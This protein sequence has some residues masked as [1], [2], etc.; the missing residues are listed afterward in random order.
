[1]GERPERAMETMKTGLACMMMTIMIGMTS[2]CASL[3]PKGP[4]QPE[5][6]VPKG[7]KSLTGSSVEA[8]DRS[9]QPNSEHPLEEVSELAPELMLEEVPEGETDS[10]GALEA[11]IDRWDYLRANPLN[12]NK[13]SR[14]QL[15]ML[16]GI[17][18]FWVDDLLR[19]RKQKGAFFSPKEA[20]EATII[21]EF[22]WRRWSTYVTVGPLP[23]RI[24]ARLR[25]PSAWWSEADWSL[26]TT[27]RSA[28][29][30]LNA[31]DRPPA[32]FWEP[33]GLRYRLRWTSP[34]F[35]L[36]MHLSPEYGSGLLQKPISAA[37][38][39]LASLPFRGELILGTYLLGYGLGLSMGDARVM[40]TGDQ[41]LET[42]PTGFKHRSYIGTSYSLPHRG[43]S[44]SIGDSLRW[45][46]WFSYRPYLDSAQDIEDTF[47]QPSAIRNR[48]GWAAYEPSPSSDAGGRIPITLQML[49][50]RLEY[51][52]RRGQVALSWWSAQLIVPAASTLNSVALEGEMSPR[53][54]PL[55]LLSLD[56]DWVLPFGHFQ[57]EVALDRRGNPAGILHLE[58]EAQGGFRWLAHYRHLRPGYESPFGKTYTRWGTIPGNE[59]GLYLGW[60]Y[61]PHRQ[62]R[63][64]SFGDLYQSIEPRTNQL[65]PHQGVLYGVALEWSP[66]HARLLLKARQRRESSEEPL[67]DLYGRSY[68]GLTEFLQ[69]TLEARIEGRITASLQGIQRLML[70]HTPDQHGML[71]AQELRWQPHKSL[72]VHGRVATYHTDSDGPP[73]YVY[74]PDPVTMGR[75]IRLSGLGIRTYLLLHFQPKDW[76]KLQF[77][78]MDQELPLDYFLPEKGHLQQW[79]LR[80]E[81][82]DPRT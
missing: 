48:L 2:A 1:M 81:L 19:A 61:Q 42:S 50:Q 15:S 43:I 56:T 4:G 64:L 74:E 21:P 55:R 51:Q 8:S 73:L 12:L 6:K 22:V 70:V 67:V 38:L 76:I 63:W 33:A 29:I 57:T 44:L 54:H 71:I 53:Y 41:L 27:M 14:S 10:H 26:S 25:T 58:G 66:K 20:F 35:N 59:Q 3:G 79:S 78:W 5:A 18:T 77:K 60:Q 52:H 68:T 13:A 16:P 7:S 75:S 23:Q 47:G 49:G 24:G 30:D 40:P 82:K 46:V 32:S 69:S 9:S 17:K 80:L 65:Y 62:W 36:G 37:S 28:T 34:W 31:R 39:Q 11:Y 72:R 45:S